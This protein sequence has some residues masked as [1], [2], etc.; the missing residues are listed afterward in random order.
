[1]RVESEWDVICVGAGITSLAFGAE[2]VLDHPGARVLITDKHAI[3]GGYATWFRRPKVSA[4]FECSLHKLSGMAL[5]G[6]LR[7]ILE[8]LTLGSGIQFV[9]AENFF[10]Y[11]SPDSDLE[12][13]GDERVAEQQL[14][15][16]FP[17]D[18][19]GIATFFEDV[20]THGKNGYFQ[21]QTLSG[22]YDPPIEQLQ[23]ARRHLKKITVAERFAQLFRN[24]ALKD[25]LAS[26]S[27]YVGG[28]PEQ[29]SYLYYLH[30]IYATLNQGSAYLVGSAQKL[31]N[32][33]AAVIRGAGGAVLVGNPARRILWNERMAAVGVETHMG[34]FFA[35]S[36]Y[37]NAAPKY[38]MTELFP[39]LEDRPLVQRKLESL[40][41]SSS[42]TTLYLLTDAPPAEL[43]FMCAESMLYGRG[44]EASLRLRH[45]ARD[46]PGLME[47]AYWRAGTMEITNYN[48]VDP[49]GVYAVVAN[50]LD[51]IDHWP[52]RRSPGYKPKKARAREALLD[53]MLAAFPALHGR[54]R[55]IELSTPRTYERFTNNTAGSGF[56]AMVGPDVSGFGFHQG[57]P[58]RGVRFLSSWVAGPGY[59]AAFGYAEMH[60]A[61]WA[62]AARNGLE[63]AAIQ[64]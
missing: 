27:I 18:A 25:L 62:R 28:F 14:R 40:Q 30:V 53:R 42:V 12:I 49:E 21:F 51:V 56:G 33:L 41:N 7:R 36:I 59:E 15:R 5:G 46:R 10:R 54:V 45:A 17:A 60:A 64:A 11:V 20:R 4:T 44:H 35:P 52:Q 9:A 8:R 24:D 1:M 31:S 61:K 47:D 58:V 50:V 29:M 57:F 34:R 26:P 2:L 6:N 63:T 3:P 37:I 23:Y 43:G 38:A 13:D 48:A 19:V 16:A 22:D 55:Y 39:D 32:H